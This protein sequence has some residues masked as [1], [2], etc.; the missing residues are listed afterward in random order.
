MV[1]GIKE[2]KNSA[3]CILYFYTEKVLIE[4]SDGKDVFE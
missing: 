1:G 2:I 4:D 3:R